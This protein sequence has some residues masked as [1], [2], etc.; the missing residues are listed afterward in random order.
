MEINLGKLAFAWRGAYDGATEYTNKDVVSFGGS[1]Y[2]M[3]HDTP[4]TGVAPDVTTHWDVLAQGAAAVTSG[5]PA[6]VVVYTASHD[7]PTGWLLANGAVVSRT[8]YADLFNAIGT[9]YGSGDGSTTFGIPELRGEFIRGV[10]RLR[11]VDAGRALGSYQ[12]DEVGPHTHTISF[13]DSGNAGSFDSS[14]STVGTGAT[15]TDPMNTTETRPRNVALTA[16][17]KH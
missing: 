11:G 5:T 4:A 10:D 2:I 17:I 15:T 3:K 16:I 14:D 8:T 7:I 6:G 12:S 13:D 1:S 9:T